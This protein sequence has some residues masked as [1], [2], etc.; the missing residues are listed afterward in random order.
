MEKLND[1]AVALLKGKNFV[2][3][4]TVNKNGSPQA[5][6]L[7]VD[8]DGKNVLINTAIGRVKD[9]NMKRDARVGI[10]IFDLKNPYY[11]VHLDGKVA[12][13]ITGKKAEDHISFLSEK[14][15]GI[16]PY[17]KDDPAQKRIIYVIEPT[18][19]REQ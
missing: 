14:Y 2:T 15:T 19:I 13:T 10:A 11:R 6:T 7:W 9:R 8:T 12:K 3:V 1:K 4:A 17:K 18:H 16:T 5:T